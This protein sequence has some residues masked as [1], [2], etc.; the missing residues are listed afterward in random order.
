MKERKKSRKFCRIPISKPSPALFLSLVL[1]TLFSLPFY[2]TT[3]SLIMLEP[4]QVSLLLSAVYA[5]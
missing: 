1:S 4:F 5:R 2:P 3:H